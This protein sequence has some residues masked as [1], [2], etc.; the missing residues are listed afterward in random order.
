[1]QSICSEIR[2]LDYAKTNIQFTITSLKRL[3]MLITGIEQLREFCINKQYKEAAN[4]IEATEELCN[5]FKDYLSIKQI[6]DLKKEREHLCTELR[7]QILEE[8]RFLD[9]G[10]LPA[11]LYEACFAIDALGPQAV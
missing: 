8:F 1:M 2:S 6:S 7:L 5:Y 10:N 9:Q 4:L 3:I 11:L